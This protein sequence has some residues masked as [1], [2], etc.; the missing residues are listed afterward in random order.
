M[1]AVVTQ[2]DTSHFERFDSLNGG[3]CHL[4]Q[5]VISFGKLSREASWLGE[6]GQ[7]VGEHWMER[8]SCQ[9]K[10]S[11]MA[12][13]CCSTNGKKVSFSGEAMRVIV[14]RVDI[15][16]HNSMKVLFRKSPFYLFKFVSTPVY[17]LPSHLRFV[18]PPK[19]RI[20]PS[21]N[22]INK[23]RQSSL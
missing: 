2:Q 15:Y 1:H 16:L 7:E 9:D 20:F 22:K 8:Q 10:A 12:K 21:A 17:P 4:I 13:Q 18:F 14:F 23:K 5:L 11:I 6:S 19:S 3:F